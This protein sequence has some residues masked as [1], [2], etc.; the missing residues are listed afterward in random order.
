MAAESP[1][2]PSPLSW[3]VTPETNRWVHLLAYG[4]YAPLGAIALVLAVGGVAFSLVAVRNGSIGLVLLL[5]VAVIV[6]LARPPVLA[7]ILDDEVDTSSGYDGW[8][9]SWR[10]VLAASVLCGAA[11]LA[12][13]LH[14]RVAMGA[15]AVASFAAGLLAMTLTTEA[16]IDE[17]LRLETQY[18]AVDLRTL[19]GVRSVDIGDATIVWLAY[20]RGADGFRNPRVLAVPRERAAE[21][22]ER[23]DA[24]VAADPDAD[25]IGRVERVVVALFGLGVLATAPGFWLL[26][27]DAGADETLVLLYP[28]ALSLVFAGPMLWYAW[29]G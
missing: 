19:S 8:Q 18:T 25:P 12:A 11:I 6:A 27:G 10:G 29:K 26:I 22:R 17:D 5:G 16:T 9:P 15:V 13:S 24:G 20:A 23:L 4:L 21:V 2:S 1:R 14:S 28:V 7:A 3:A